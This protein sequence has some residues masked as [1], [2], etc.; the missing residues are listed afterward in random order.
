MHVRWKL[1]LSSEAPFLSLDDRC[2]PVPDSNHAHPLLDLPL[3]GTTITYQCQLGYLINNRA[4]FNITCENGEWSE[5]DYQ[6]TSN[7]HLV[8]S[9]FP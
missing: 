4:N 8:D 7:T 5:M 6:C 2:P 1:M 3:D 9:V